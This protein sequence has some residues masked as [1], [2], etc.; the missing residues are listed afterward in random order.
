MIL[1]VKFLV[2]AAGKIYNELWDDLRQ[3][4]GTTLLTLALVAVIIVLG[5]AV[6]GEINKKRSPQIII[7]DVQQLDP[8]DQY[9]S[10]RPT[11]SPSPES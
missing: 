4:K 2:S 11:I 5:L 1:L 8:R 3:S 6:W 10:P 9:V 7:P